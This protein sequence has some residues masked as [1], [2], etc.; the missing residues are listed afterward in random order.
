MSEDVIVLSEERPNWDNVSDLTISRTH[1][2]TPSAQQGHGI[3][4][5]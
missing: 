5:G 4:T 3:A 1:T 2:H